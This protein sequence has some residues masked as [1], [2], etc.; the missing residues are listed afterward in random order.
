MFQFVNQCRH[1]GR[2]P[3]EKMH[4]A[5]IN[6]VNETEFRGVKR[7]AGKMEPLKDR[8]NVLWVSAS[9]LVLIGAVIFAMILVWRPDLLGLK[10]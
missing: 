9:G 8:A 2:N 6:G 1:I 5:F 10:V 7:L 4:F 3:A